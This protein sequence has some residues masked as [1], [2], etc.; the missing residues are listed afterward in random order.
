MV[1]VVTQLTSGDSATEYSLQVKPPMVDGLTL[2]A[3][4]MEKNDYGNGSDDA[5]DQQE[6]NGA[7]AVS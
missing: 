6:R 1:K 3:S 4:Y 5:G 2:S 7:Y